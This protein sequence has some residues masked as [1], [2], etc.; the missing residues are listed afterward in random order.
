M[1]APEDLGY[2]PDNVALTDF[3]L[4]QPQRLAIE[5]AEATGMETLDLRPVLSAAAECPYQP[6]NMHWLE[7]GHQLVADA[8]AELLRR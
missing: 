2:F 3:D 8:V 6:E 7:R 1:C 4:D 5:I